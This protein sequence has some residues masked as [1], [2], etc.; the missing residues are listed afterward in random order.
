M[1][2]RYKLIT[3]LLGHPQGFLQ[4]PARPVGKIGLTS[5]YPRITPDNPVQSLLQGLRVYPAFLQQVLHHIL[6][7]TE[8][9]LQKVTR[10]HGLLIAGLRNLDGLLY[11]LLRLY[12]KIIEVHH[13]RFLLTSFRGTNMKPAAKIRQIVIIFW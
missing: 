8:Q 4:Y 6:R 9:P 12:R 3:H 5:R 7:L 10:L 1:L 11:G 2:Y 13:I